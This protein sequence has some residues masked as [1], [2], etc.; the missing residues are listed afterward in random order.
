MSVSHD[1][2]QV[3]DFFGTPHEIEP[4]SSQLS[5]DAGLQRRKT[6]KG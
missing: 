1:R 3:L 4:S 2:P 5:R 6:G